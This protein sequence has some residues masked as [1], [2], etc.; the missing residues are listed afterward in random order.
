MAVDTLFNDVRLLL[1]SGSLTNAATS[2]PATVSSAGVTPGAALTFASD[3]IITASS[4]SLANP[5]ALATL[6]LVVTPTWEPYSKIASMLGVSLNAVSAGVIGIYFVENDTATLAGSLTTAQSG[7]V[8]LIAEYI[9]SGTGTEIKLT[10]IPLS[11]STTTVT[12]SAATPSGSVPATLILGGTPSIPVPVPGGSAT[13][14]RVQ[15]PRA[16]YSQ[17][18]IASLRNTNPS[19]SVIYDPTPV[20]VTAT[21][22]GVSHT[23][24]VSN[25]ANRT[26]DDV[27]SELSLGISQL[28]GAVLMAETGY[29]TGAEQRASLRL[30][31]T[32]ISSDVDNW[33]Y[34]FVGMPYATATYFLTGVYGANPP[35]SQIST[36]T[37]TFTPGT[38]SNVSLTA[39]GVTTT[40]STTNMAAFVAA[41][42][43][44]LS[45][46][47]TVSAIYPFAGQ[48]IVYVT[49]AVGIEFTLAATLTSG[50]AVSSGIATLTAA[51]V[52]SRR[53]YMD[54][55][56]AVEYPSLPWPTS[57]IPIGGGG[58]APDPNTLLLM[59]FD[60]SS[61]TT[62]ADDTGRT[63][64]SIN[65]L[66]VQ[67]G[68][69]GKF[70]RGL[71]P[72]SWTAA[73]GSSPVNLSG[74]IFTIEF[75]VTKTNTG[76]T[77]YE[78]VFAQTTSPDT[79]ANGIVLFI[80][81]TNGLAVAYMDG[82]PSNSSA[83]MSLT[84]GTWIHVALVRQGS[85]ASQTKWYVNGTGSAGFQT[86]Y[87]YTSTTPTIGNTVGQT[88]SLGYVGIDELRISDIARYTANFTPPTAP[89]DIG[90]GGGPT[91]D[92][93]LAGYNDIES[94]TGDGTF[95]TQANAPDAYFFSA[96]TAD[97]VT[98]TGDAYTVDGNGLT[99]TS[100]RTLA[101]ATNTG[102][103]VR[104]T[105]QNFDSTVTLD[106]TTAVSTFYA[107][108][109]KEWTGSATLEDVTQFGLIALLAPA[110]FIG[111]SS[112][113]DAASD[114]TF[115]VIEPI[116]WR[117]NAEVPTA[118]LSASLS[119]P[120][121]FDVNAKVPS[122][123]LAAWF[124]MRL[125]KTVP[126][127][128]LQA[129]GIVPNTLRLGSDLPRVT[130][131]ANILNG[132]SFSLQSNVPPVSLS[133]WSGWQLKASVPAASAV[134]MVV[135][136]G[137][138]RVNA[139]V[140]MASV[141]SSA[142]AENVLRLTAMVPAAMRSGWVAVN[143]TVPAARM[144][145]SIMPVVAITRLAY[146]FT[147]ANSA[148]TRYPSYPFIQVIRIG[149]AYY[150]IAEDGL[151]ELGGTT[152]NGTAI[153]W[154]F[155]TCMS[156]FGMAEKK[157][158]V[159]A[160][161]GGYVPQSMA[162]TIKAGDL[163]TGTNAH[164]TTATA[165]LRNHRQKFGI[166]RKSRFFAF[167]LS[168]TQGRVAIESI[169]FEMA[170]MSRRV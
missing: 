39:Y 152:D 163:P 118:K 155:E 68:A 126:S 18:Q 164:T 24:T 59:H 90:G 74:G 83:A 46:L 130:L 4:V 50:T 2:S 128:R 28:T 85:G 170:S 73:A 156:D 103:F 139:T 168:A 87:T 99:F 161:L 12:V 122:A 11:G 65:D 94:F 110:G 148:M 167:G 71:M 36:A 82:A 33:E 153:P 144:I 131:A 119:E 145:G 150:G 116:T 5:T 142:V 54:D 40:G 32:P 160:Y 51:R 84:P 129:V 157:T 121:S 27:L 169:E 100:T 93:T 17:Q 70:G 38:P 52:T 149:N 20:S 101:A 127:A 76:S 80:D 37:Y 125:D 10:A 41:A 123:S 58:G 1:Q 91:A 49:G 22:V 134:G 31:F 95:N 120:D 135:V 35:L 109:P 57:S 15:A 104:D 44:A 69:A 111:A 112:L 8:T 151:Y 56:A 96:A 42:S 13:V 113:D 16:S 77:G 48:C 60:E 45:T 19:N 133:A 62:L 7:E 147:L 140:P 137:A 67:T 166:G 55:G 88:Y 6:E 114:S 30:T 86:S 98:S 165:V 53:R 89:F 132:R 61:G 21:A 29:F 158:V 92:V 97:D 3:G 47:A 105:P 162:Y 141:S 78:V 14:A 124:G 43:S 34:S 64:S 159:S 102:T 26:V 108:T 66:S 117:V 115:D 138:Y 136:G 143:K 154:S 72:T 75:W 79:W 25:P 63:F 146:S 9:L 81:S 107:D 23:Y 106:D